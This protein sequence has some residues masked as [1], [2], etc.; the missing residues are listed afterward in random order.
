MNLLKQMSMSRKHLQKN[1]GMQCDNRGSSF[2]LVMVSIALIMILVAIVFTMMIMQFKMLTLGRQSKDNFYYLEEVLEEMRVG[3][4]NESVNQLKK[5]YDETVSMVV[6]YDTNQNKYL[7][8]SADA[9]K[10]ILNSKFLNYIKQYFDIND[11]Y[12]A[13]LL[14]SY[15]KDVNTV[16][17]AD[18]AYVTSDGVSITF[19][20]AFECEEVMTTNPSS[21][22]GYMIKDITV[23]RTDKKGN[24]QSI[25]TDISIYPPEDALNFLGSTT[26]LEN[27]FTYA[28]VADYGVE[29]SGGSTTDVRVAGNVYAA[30]DMRNNGIY[31]AT[32]DGT[33]KLSGGQRGG[34]GRTSASAYSGIFVTD[35]GTSLNLQS[36]IM[37]VNG[38]IA[39]NNGAT[40]NGNRK[41]DDSS[42][43]TMANLWADNI[44][45]LG[46]EGS[47]IYMHAQ[48]SLS[49]DLELNGE[50]SD[51]TLAGHY[52]G[53]NYA[54]E[55]EYMA[56]VSG[57]ATP[58]N[59]ISSVAPKTH[60]N[61]SAIMINGEGSK[62]NLSK[63]MIMVVNGRSYIDLV[64]END[65]SGNASGVKN[66]DIDIKTAESISSKGTQLVYRVLDSRA[67]NTSLSPLD[68]VG[69]KQV[70][71]EANEL[72]TA[73]PTYNMVMCLA[74]QFIKDGGYRIYQS[75]E[76][77]DLRTKRDANGDY[78]SG[79]D[80]ST[81][82]DVDEK[83]FDDVW[84][85][86]KSNGTN[87]KY[88]N[89]IMLVYFP[90]DKV[91]VAK[92]K[93]DGSYDR[94]AAGQIKYTLKN[95]DKF[96]VRDSYNNSYEI[97]KNDNSN[98]RDG[99]DIALVTKTDASEK[100]IVEGINRYGFMTVG[101]N[102]DL[103]SLVKT[104]VGEAKDVYYY[105]QFYDEA[106][107][108][109]FVLDY[110]EFTRADDT[111][112]DVTSLDT[113]SSELMEL[114]DEERNTVYTRGISTILNATTQKYELKPA[115]TN[116]NYD[117]PELMSLY[118][119][120]V[121]K[122]NVYKCYFPK[123]EASIT[124]AQQTIAA[125]LFQTGTR[126]KNPYGYST[127]GK[128]IS[129]LS[130]PDCV[131]INWSQ[132]AAKAV[133]NGGSGATL[134]GYTGA[135]V[136]ISTGDIVIKGS[137]LPGASASG[138]VLCQG[139]VT[140]ENVKE[141]TG[142][143]ICAG[144]LYV[145]GATNFY[146]DEQMCNAMIE[147][148]KTNMIRTCFGL[149]EFKEDN[150]NSDKGKSIS[151]IEYTDLVGFEHWLKNGE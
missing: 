87:S 28:M 80:N 108:T 45:T 124:S 78:I 103:I 41:S 63:L 109:E 23:T 75:K 132:V 38:S 130:N 30:S 148:D 120:K 102:Y 8:V 11:A 21:V 32:I 131:E 136:W 13:K 1:K 73:V 62:L 114:P 85:D 22:V 20:S 68:T 77:N 104:V 92:R 149:K 112:D 126:S 2:V 59:Q 98:N 139:D 144:K 97:W 123:S 24:E 88:Y 76:G 145:K 125:N 37:S 5:A 106:A 115:S 117:E 122:S 7:S 43:T 143:I 57:E 107:K 40:I 128:D 42:S 27:V 17:G 18:G 56:M 82:D 81:W 105:Y 133:T 29:I 99:S 79:E 35:S 142:T 84:K 91:I 151:N 129:P 33:G 36:D 116:T 3:V 12:L 135:R 113:F 61:S 146:A 150:N 46:T 66:T 110:S 15:V 51:V 60:T 72:T 31:K 71:S 4:G 70:G 55:E 93:G 52:Y 96:K 69:T 53:Y 65:A 10:G 49:D 83:S 111:I 86:I 9:A 44:A 118:Q 100:L 74:Y 26:D 141:F 16:P 25:T 89:D 64:A 138:I 14:L 58:K 134:E 94:N 67:I 47:S 54:A 95:N 6:M 90:T 48:S 140:F 127:K 137:D 121:Q 50:K 119:E 19:G 39:A 147:N 34:N 101:K